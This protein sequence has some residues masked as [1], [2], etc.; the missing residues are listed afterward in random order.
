MTFFGLTPEYKVSLH[1]EVFELAYYSEGA[2]TQD[3]AYKLPIYLRRFYYKKLADAKKKE[4]EET[5]KSNGSSQSSMP[6][7]PSIPRPNIPR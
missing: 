7:M 1:S 4:K 6:S 5:E 3:I 2:F